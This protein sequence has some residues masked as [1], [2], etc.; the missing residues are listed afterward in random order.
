MLSR[1]IQATRFLPSTVQWISTTRALQGGQTTVAA[2]LGSSPEK[3]MTVDHLMPAERAAQLMV[4]HHIDAI[5]VLKDD[6]VLSERCVVG[7]FTEHDYFD[8]VLNGSQMGVSSSKVADVATMH[9]KL[10]V[11]HPE[12][13]V[14]GCLQVMIKRR[15][16]AIP[17][18]K[19]DG[20][21]VGTVSMMDLTKE[22]LARGARQDD[23]QAQYSHNTKMAATHSQPSHFPENMVH[24]G[25]GQHEDDVSTASPEQ[26]HKLYEELKH[27]L[28]KHGSARTD[29]LLHRASMFDTAA[30]ERFHLDTNLD[31]SAAESFSEASTFPEFTPTEDQLYTQTHASREMV[32]MNIA[33]E[34]K[35]WKEEDK[36]A[37]AQ[38]EFLSEAVE[39]NA[40]F[41]EPSDFPEVSSVEE[42][43]AARKRTM[44]TGNSHTNN[45]FE[46]RTERRETMV[47]VAA[48]SRPL[49]PPPPPPAFPWR[50]RCRRCKELLARG[51]QVHFIRENE[52]SNHL[53]LRKHLFDDEYA[54][55]QAAGDGVGYNRKTTW[56][57]DTHAHVTPSLRF[58]KIRT[59]KAK[60]RGRVPFELLCSGCQ[61]KFA[62]ECVLD[63]RPEREFLLDSKS[64]EIVLESGEP[65]GAH[66]GSAIRKWGVV[67][68]ALNSLNL[69][70]TLENALPQAIFLETNGNSDACGSRVQ[71]T[72]GSSSSPPL[73]ESKRQRAQSRTRSGVVMPTEESVW[74]SFTPSGKLTA[75]RLYQV[76]LALSALFENTIV[77]LPTGAGKTLVAVKVIDDM[78]RLNPGLLAV[79]FVPTG[80]L[81]TQQAAYIRRESE[82]NVLEL[83]GQHTAKFASKRRRLVEDPSLNALVVTPMYFANLLFNHIV[84]VSD[85]CVMVFDEAHHATGDH[86]Y[87]SILQKIAATPGESRPRILALTA[88]PFGEAKHIESGQKTLNRLVECFGAQANTPTIRAEDLQSILSTKEAQWVVVEPSPAEL[89]LRIQLKK[90]VEALLVRVAEALGD[91]VAFVGTNFDMD[92]MELTQLLARLR[93]LQE[94]EQG[95]R[96]DLK[97]TDAVLLLRHARAI[98]SSFFDLAIHGAAH[99]AR[100]LHSRFKN[101]NFASSPA[102]K[103]EYA[104]IFSDYK[105][106]LLSTVV[107]F[108]SKYSKG[109]IPET[110]HVSSRVLRV[111]ECIKEANFTHESRAIVFVRRRKTAI[112]LAKAMEKVP[113]L[114]RL[115]PT[116]FIG[117]NSY[118]GM[119]WEEEQKPTLN[120]F[121]QGWIR[122]LVATN[123][124]EEGL[125]VPEC[126]LVIQFDGIKGMTSL[127][128]SRG[129]ARRDNSRFIVFCSPGGVERQQKI[130][131]TEGRLFAVAQRVA[132][133]LPSKSAAQRFLDREV[134]VLVPRL[135]AASSEMKAALSDVH[136]SPIDTPENMYSIILGS[137]LSDHDDAFWDA[138]LAALDEHAAVRL[139]ESS[140]GLCTLEPLP[141][142]SIVQSYHKLCRSLDFQD[143]HGGGRLWMKFENT[144]VDPQLKDLFDKAD[145]GLKLRLLELNRGYWNASDEFVIAEQID[146]SD[147]ENGS[148]S[149][150][151]A[152][153]ML[154]VADKMAIRLDLRQLSDQFVWFDAASSNGVVSLFVS[155]Q[156][157]PHF[158]RSGARIHTNCQYKSLVFH[159]KVGCVSS[160]GIEAWQ[161]RL[162]LTK[163]G[164]EVRDSLVS[165]VERDTFSNDTSQVQPR[166]QFTFDVAYAYHC[167]QSR[168]SYFTN[169][170]LDPDFYKILSG[171]DHGVQEKVL[172]AFQPSLKSG[173][174]VDLFRQYVSDEWTTLKELSSKREDVVF[175][176][177]VTP[178]RVLFRPPESAPNNRVFRHFGARNFMY[179]YFRD[180]NLDRLEYSNVEIVKQLRSVMAK[181]VSVDNVVDGPCL[182][183]FLGSSL[184]QMR[185]SSCVFTSLDP[186]VVRSWVGDLSAIHSPAKY[187]KRLS[188][189]F[190]STKPA[191]HVEQQ[192]V[193]NPVSD[194]EYGGF[195][196]TDGCGEITKHGAAKI[197]AALNLRSV[198]SAFQIRL[199][200]AKGVVVVSNVSNALED[201]GDGIV[202]RKSMVKFR[203]QHRV[204]EVVACAGRSI[205]YL[206]RQS[207]QILSG[208]GIQDDIFL[209]MQDEYLEE[210]SSMIASDAEAYFVLKGVLPAQI[211]WSIQ[212]L[213]EQLG[214]PLFS[215]G[216]LASIVNAIYRYKLTNTVLRARIPITKGRTLMGVADFTSTLKYGE[217][218]VQYTEKDEES[219]EYHAIILDQTDVVIHRSPCHHP[220]DIRIVRCRSD[221]PAQLR[222]LKDCIVFPCDGPRPHPDECTGGDLDGDVFTVIWDER[223]IPKRENVEAPMEF[224]SAMAA[225][226]T[227]GVDD[228]SL[229]DFY[230]KSI[231]FDILGIASNAHLAVCD[232]SDKGI[233]DEGALELARICSSQVDHNHADED[234]ERVRSLAPKIYP[235]FMRNSEKGSY[236]SKK[237]LGQMYRRCDAIMEATIARIG[238]VGAEVDSD[239]LVDGYRDHLEI[240]SAMY[241]QY[242]HQVS[243]LLLSS[244][245]KS[246]AELA[247]GMIV[248]PESLNKAEYFR[249]GDQCRDAFYDLQQSFRNEF[250][251][252]FGVLQPS[253]M[254]QVAAA[255]HCVAYNDPDTETRCLSFPWVMIDILIANKAS[256][257]RAYRQKLW[258]PIHVQTRK[259]I[260]PGLQTSL[261]A[262]IQEKMDEFLSDLFDRQ[263]ALSALHSSL[264]AHFKSR[265]YEL[266]LFGSSALLT[267]EKQSDLDVMIY[268]KEKCSELKHVAKFLE[269][270]KSASQLERKEKVRVPLLSF[271]YDQ[272]FVELCQSSNGPL[273]TRLFRTYMEKYPFFWP[274]VYFL[275]R[276]GKCAGVIRRRSGGGQNLF[277][278]TGFMWLF[279]RFCLTNNFVEK[280]DWR[281]MAIEPILEQNTIDAEISFWTE[282]LKKLVT[283]TPDSSASAA[284]VLLSFLSYYANLSTPLSEFGFEDPFDEANNTQ[285]SEA[286]V[287]AFQQ[288]CHV[289]VHLLLVSRGDIHCLLTQQ[290][291]QTSKV[292]LSRALSKRVCESKDF[293]AR[294]ILIE[295]K[296]SKDTT[297]V[298]VRHPN[299]FRPDLYVAEIYGDGDSVQR[300]EEKLQRIEQELGAPTLK[301]SIQSFHR[302][303][304]SLVLFE[305]AVS[306]E[307]QIGFQVYLGERHTLH[308]HMPLHQ[309][310]LVCFMNGQEWYNHASACFSAR[311]IQQMIKF[312][313]FE[314]IHSGNGQQKP[315][316]DAFIRFGHHY[317]INLPRSFHDETIALASIKK[318]EEEFER[319]R[320]ARELYESVLVVKQKERKEEAE[321]EARQAEKAGA[322]GDGAGGGGGGSGGG[323]GD[324]F[325]FEADSGEKADDD[326]KITLPPKK[327]VVAL[328][329]ASLAA[330]K[331]KGVTHS[332]YTRLEKEHGVKVPD[333]AM[334][335]KRMELLNS[336]ETYS[337]SI[338]Y[339]L[340]DYIIKLT[341]DLQF[342]KL[343][344]RASR[345]FSATLKMRQ[346][347]DEVA[348]TMDST[349]DV[350][351]YVSTTEQVPVT[352][353]LHEKL[354]AYCR[355]APDGRGILAFVDD[356]KSR[357]RLSDQMIATGVSGAI[358]TVRH[359]R[360]DTYACPHTG[361]QLTLMR[362]REFTTPSLA[363]EE[364]FLGVKDKL[365]AEFTMPP[366]TAE[367]RHDPAFAREFL[368]TGVEFVDF[369]RSQSQL[370]PLDKQAEKWSIAVDEIDDSDASNRE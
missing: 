18:V 81:V 326:V 115:N 121:R 29:E 73:F 1:A 104:L 32:E 340:V 38:G 318:L 86:P 52:S 39:E 120:R 225:D 22:M 127:I 242:K 72:S 169:G 223:L 305:G 147:G 85:F 162:L 9:S 158:Y 61:I 310:H 362:I 118:E 286:S 259:E 82:L 266:V 119:S 13:T 49:P 251:S 41:S 99:V 294:K 227:E 361:L 3:T 46:K 35:L 255:W 232:Y 8:K 207:I 315:K 290:R 306:Q 211:S 323:G 208:L 116:R 143:G 241:R 217:V 68:S 60:K 299:S 197:A 58:T 198:P 149:F 183:Q 249:F 333:Y 270:S 247:T 92:D 188:Q 264:A 112:E 53:A 154:E 343:K 134:P 175:K 316:A 319:G 301:R 331:D 4:K 302:E 260:I 117:H 246:E 354:A 313:R 40:T 322:G 349:P 122:L 200:G 231:Q 51:D 338:V 84:A 16:S 356:T 244:G 344:T 30:A 205:A 70:V 78:V 179:V 359:V 145:Q 212:I 365:E 199:G 168:V 71:G 289:A 74:Y 346:E 296:A 342:V 248:E 155:L 350:R 95:F 144:E 5:P 133:S 300:I 31:E 214:V 263:V 33:T 45:Q 66:H 336:S 17:V 63:E 88:S 325:D 252:K 358:P 219:D 19:G 360:A 42:L 186:D 203:S 287:P 7:M 76:E 36:Y 91:E 280:I 352:H 59:A 254:G 258:K 291:D 182:F 235:D 265:P 180:E 152:S 201:V 304:S 351:F 14:E 233:F 160:A 64:C 47:S 54:R 28:E 293:F 161:M 253:R 114:K 243:A 77:Y 256:R 328:E 274:C 308:D 279:L 347:L 196:F 353:P 101:M 97:V 109:A 12:D 204:L 131:D 56:S 21:V 172:L 100:A 140:L 222:S 98:V 236:P 239:L 277:S 369:L 327:R 125:D 65:L 62:G 93:L 216:F 284:H 281:K 314:K 102:A 24:A 224:Q 37:Q 364:G 126:S 75:L 250:A 113:E 226:T 176:V 271:S 57:L 335:N 146:T 165:V 218:F 142:D 141:K 170:A 341:S 181:G 135:P 303:G 128:Q 320:S 174:M 240:A 107:G 148:I 295:S 44:T 321:E 245:A 275:V 348:E 159:A 317:L 89:T 157:P 307:D 163:L 309:A 55:L 202:L 90:Y 2:L 130:V 273:K 173:Y 312:S 210:L 177:I 345:W 187:L 355:Q 292:T 261:L 329:K 96:S 330:K 366:L 137:M 6:K 167:F 334:S 209:A 363:P 67:L 184:S 257:T 153:I 103:K 268:S 151:G 124:L 156:V 43:I 297:L 20:R 357:V 178:T 10:V 83:S 15:L 285:L 192:V 185:N 228:Q 215:D 48:T 171:L 194:F 337:A 26:L 139:V 50:I 195:V 123:V 206:T 221:V 282:H 189:A 298:F 79:F 94:R 269:K 87:R 283:G 324:F 191:F 367:R 138:I 105:A 229:I 27:D 110:E 108:D 339:D 34:Q 150:H 238:G 132:S 230:L 129:R 106:H 288:E 25:S 267:F 11:A 370:A 272:W 220:G 69:P 80:P 166:L 278:P 237:I 193:E 262:E 234:I 368:S 136:L 164:I 213:L 190:S 23:A 276:W 332:F 311:F 111:A